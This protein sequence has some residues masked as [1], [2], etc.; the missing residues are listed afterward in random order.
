[1]PPL[2]AAGYHVIAPDQ[3]G[4]GRTTGWDADYDGD[5]CSSRL[6]NWCA[7]RSGWC[8]HRQSRVDAWSARFR[9]AR[10]PPGAPCCGP[11]VPLGGADER[12]VRWQPPI[13]YATAERRRSEP[14]IHIDDLAAL[15]RPRKH[16]QRYYSTRDANDDMRHAPQGLH[17]FLR[18]YY[19]RRARTGPATSRTGWRAGPRGAGQDAD[20]LI[21][22]LAK[23]M[24][25]TVA[26]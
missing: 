19:H 17:D 9:L 2:A 4:Y 25:E 21:M 1:M 5:L 23:N 7:M 20:V 10:S 13:P 24:A 15:P 12:A 26:P 6:L 16:Y 11:N 8:R 22:D 14:T 18:A 3:R